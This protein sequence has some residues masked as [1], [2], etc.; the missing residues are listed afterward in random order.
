MIMQHGWSNSYT[1]DWK[2]MHDYHLL[3]PGWL[4]GRLEGWLCRT[5]R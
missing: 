2:S 3:L 4:A 5:Q 1:E